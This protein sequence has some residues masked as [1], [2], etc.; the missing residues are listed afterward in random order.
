[1]AVAAVLLACSRGG[2]K[3]F[4]SISIQMPAHLKSAVPVG[5]VACYGVNVTGDGLN[6]AASNMC[7]PV[8]AFHS[9]F[10]AAGQDVQLTVPRNKTIQVDLYL[11]L[12]PSG[13]STPC[14]DWNSAMAA[15]KVS[16]VY[17]L[18]T[19]A[20]VL[21]DTDQK[22]INITANY[23][24]TSIVSSAGLSS[25]CT[26][27]SSAASS[28]YSLSSGAMT[29]TGANAA[30]KGKVGTGGK[31]LLTSATASILVK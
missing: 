19:A 20:N 6:P 14:P 2:E 23:T 9:N 27:N 3:T 21:T 8:S 16:N 13:T 11:Y 31:Q 18:G 15:G 29:A 17:L 10:V 22:V 28:V 4:S 1:M 26:G 5:Q 25:A 7:S 12:E 30:I 24:G